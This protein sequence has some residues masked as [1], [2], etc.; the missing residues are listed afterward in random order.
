MPLVVNK[1]KHLCGNNG[2]SK[3]KWEIISVYS[4][5]LYMPLQHMASPLLAHLWIGAFCWSQTVLLCSTFNFFLMFIL[6]LI[7]YPYYWR[8]HS[9]HKT[10]TSNKDCW[11]TFYD[12]SRLSVFAFIE[13]IEISNKSEKIYFWTLLWTCL[14]LIL[15]FWAETDE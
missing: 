5:Y 8:L 1:W 13:P 14:M 6:I 12:S 3:T 10:K 2:V 15:C 11:I 9:P 7:L 4:S